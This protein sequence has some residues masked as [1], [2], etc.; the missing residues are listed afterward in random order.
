[1]SLQRKVLIIVSKRK[2]KKLHLDSLETVVPVV[3]IHILQRDHFFHG[4][5]EASPD[6]IELD[7]ARL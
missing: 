7:T 6:L 2:Q 1:M 3:A 4:P 5:F